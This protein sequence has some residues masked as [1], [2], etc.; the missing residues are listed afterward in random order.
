MRLDASQIERILNIVS[1]HAGSHSRVSIY[2]SRLDDSAKG[3]DI[4]L[5][6][7]TASPLPRWEQARLL[8]DLEHELGLPVDILVKYVHDPDTPF[9]SMT[10]ARAVALNPAA[11]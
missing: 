7:E 4:D 1:A 5:F 3:G 8:A 10:K 9:E 6:I 2:G 11:S